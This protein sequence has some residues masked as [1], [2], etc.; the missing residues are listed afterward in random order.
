MRI[1]LLANRDL[2]GNIGVNLLRDALA[3]HEVALFLSEKVGGAQPVVPELRVLGALETTL[4]ATVV[5]PLADAAG[6]PSEARYLTFDQIA[7]ELG[8]SCET[9]PRP[10]SPESLDRMRRFAPDLAI[11][12]RYGRVLKEPFLAIPPLG[13]LNLHSGRLPWYRGILA[14]LRAL[15]AGDPVIGP[16]L[17]WITDGTIDTGPIVGI[18]EVPVHPGRSLLDHILSV[19]PPGVEMLKDAIRRLDRGEPLPSTP[20]DPKEGDYYGFPGDGEFAALAAKGFP[21]YDP[22][23]YADLL[24]CWVPTAPGQ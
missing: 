23:G 15:V 22:A 17:H 11:S 12:L 8:S 4:P 18:G 7:A 9:L 3:G 10:N 19:Y 13:T 6:R 5:W 1:A 2:H 20:Q 16:T 14:T 24:R 21:L